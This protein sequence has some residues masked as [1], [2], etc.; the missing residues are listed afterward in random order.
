[1]HCVVV[2]VHCAV[3]HSVVG[4]AMMGESYISSPQPRSVVGVRGPGV[5][6]FRSPQPKLGF[7]LG[8]AQDYN[9]QG[10]LEVL[11]NLGQ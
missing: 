3:G 4:H 2:P 11:L 7:S 8:Q 1:M 6:V 5:S 9:K 10:L